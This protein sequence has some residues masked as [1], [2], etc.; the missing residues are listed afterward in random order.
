MRL[1]H[2]TSGAFHRVLSTTKEEKMKKLLFPALFALVASLAASPPLLAGERAGAVSLSP[3]IGG[4]TFDGAQSLRTNPVYGLRL[5]YDFTDNFAAEGVFN[6]VPTKSSRGFGRSVDA[7]SYRLDLLYNFM[8]SEKLVPYLAVGGGGTQVEYKNTDHTVYAPTANVGGGLKYFITDS[9]ALR[10][11]VRQLFVFN[12]KEAGGLVFIPN[13]QGGVLPVF[14]QAGKR[15]DVQL[16]I[17]P[18]CQLPVRTACKTGTSGM[19][20]SGSRTSTSGMSSSGT[21][22]GTSSETGTRS[23]KGHHDL[24]NRI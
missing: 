16:G 13:G 3:Y 11:D 7:I 20:S 12:G 8:P 4:Y 5:G 6:Y 22:S 9:V 2:A 10:A 24:E 21:S 18:W 19:S 1:L 14:Q 15:P 23:R 17:F